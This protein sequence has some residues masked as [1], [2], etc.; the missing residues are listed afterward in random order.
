MFECAAISQEHHSVWE[1]TVAEV[2]LGSG[3]KLI[4]PGGFHDEIV[5]FIIF[6]FRIR[7]ECS[8]DFLFSI[9]FF[10]FLS[11]LFNQIL[12]LLIYNIT[13]LFAEVMKLIISK[14][15]LILLHHSLTLFKC[16]SAGVHT[17]LSIIIGILYAFNLIHQLLDK[18]DTKAISP[19]ILI[20]NKILN[21]TYSSVNLSSH[22]TIIFCGLLSLKALIVLTVHQAFVLIIGIRIPFRV[23]A[24]IWAIR[25]VKSI[26][27]SLF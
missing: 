5:E 11:C 21:G 13:L 14:L 23:I 8:C 7:V 15:K 10:I 22:N 19:I 17:F 3:L 4:L 18:E 24:L 16:N 25:G 27:F 26:G 20:H 6:P 1:S 9:D 2:D 12:F